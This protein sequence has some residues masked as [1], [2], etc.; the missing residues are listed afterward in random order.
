[1]ENADAMPAKMI[2][3]VTS[4]YNEESIIAGNVTELACYLDAV[5]PGGAWEILVT[6]DGS[7]DQTASIVAAL[8]VRD[9][10]IQLLRH[11]RNLGQ[12]RGFRTAFA[13]ARGEIVVTTDADLSYG[14]ETIG[15]LLRTIE[16]TGADIVMASPF[17]P[18]AGMHNVPIHRRLLSRWCNRYLAKASP[19]K[20]SVMTCAV[21]AYDRRVFDRMALVA[22]GMDINVEIVLKA[23]ILGLHVVEVPGALRWRHGVSSAAEPGNKR[24]RSKMRVFRSIAANG[25]LG[26]L[27]STRLLFLVPFLLGLGT[28]LVYLVTLSL[29]FGRHVTEILAQ[30]DLG[31]NAACSAALRST[32]AESPHAFFLL[33]LFAGLTFGIGAI[34]FIANQSKFYFEQTYAIL[35]AVLYESRMHNQATRQRQADA[36][37][38][39]VDRSRAA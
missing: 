24:R 8:S 36:P 12:G 31:L 2:S 26:L 3:V 20:A 19:Q 5:L 34:W 25:F 11:H 7:S 16:E 39:L 10:R 1:M 23:Q 6:D 15:R 37:V 27:F 22:D 30:G 32:F 13:H 21:R 38:C 28:S 9:N 29:M 17:L 18:G 14:T 35:S 33:T 4:V